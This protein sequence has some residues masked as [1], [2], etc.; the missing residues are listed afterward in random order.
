[1]GDRNCIKGSIMSDTKLYTY[2]ELSQEMKCSVG[3][4][5][6]WRRQGMPC[7]FFGRLVRFRL[8]DVLQWFAEKP[9]PK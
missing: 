7:L 6:K 8:D 4:L 9:H 2:Q 3:A 5:R 1:M